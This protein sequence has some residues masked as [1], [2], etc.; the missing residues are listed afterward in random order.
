MIHAI[1]VLHVLALDGKV[2]IGA[3]PLLIAS[4]ALL[5]V[6][7]ITALYANG[8]KPTIGLDSIEDPKGLQ[9]WPSKAA[10]L[11]GGVIIIFVVALMVA[12]QFDR[13]VSTGNLIFL[14]LVAILVPACPNFQSA[15]R[16]IGILA[17]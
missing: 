3:F 8:R 9:L 15:T 12:G 1:P 14:L 16:N 7:V 6:D 2:S 17:R 13:V 4:G 11:A 5:G 10:S